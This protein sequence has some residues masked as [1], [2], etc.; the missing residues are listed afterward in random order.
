MRWEWYV[1][2]EERKGRSTDG[3]RDALY[4]FSPQ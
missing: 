1:E 3:A 2:V 4:C